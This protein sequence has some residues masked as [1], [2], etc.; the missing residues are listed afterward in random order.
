MPPTRFSSEQGAGGGRAF[1]DGQRIGI[2]G[3]SPHSPVFQERG[4]A[5]VD[6][7]PLFHP[8]PGYGDPYNRNILYDWD[9]DGQADI[10]CGTQQGH[11]YF[12]RRLPGGGCAFAPGRRLK[13]TTGEDL[14]VGPPVWDDPK[15]VR[16]FTDLQGSRIHIAPA[17][18][19]G[20]GIDDLV[21][22]ETYKN[23]WVFV[24]TEPGGVDTLRPGVQAGKTLNSYRGAPRAFDWNKDGKPDLLSGLT[25]ARPGTVYVNRSTVGK[26]AFDEP[27]Q[28]FDLTYVF[29]G[30]KIYPLD[31]NQDGDEDFLIHSEF[32][33]FWA[34]G[35]FIEHGYRQAAP[36]GARSSH[37][38]CYEI[39]Q[40]SDERSAAK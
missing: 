36:A 30:A 1:I 23:I 35:T 27:I 20:D 25:V 9:K 40:R 4:T 26:P 28:P 15:A 37:G 24:N 11:I 17:D 12:H 32:Y 39:E 10:L 22:T 34:E 14:K 6:G 33:E 31:W 16:D 18:Y 8:G 38:A 3:G 2:L 7:E 29:F 5:T 21:V 19:D 13:L